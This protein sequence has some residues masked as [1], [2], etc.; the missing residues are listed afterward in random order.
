MSSPEAEV[1]DVVNGSPM[2]KEKSQD[3]RVRTSAYTLISLGAES[4]A[5][6]IKKIFGNL[7]IYFHPE[8]I[9][10]LI[11]EFSSTKVELDLPYMRQ[12]KLPSY[13]NYSLD[14][15]ICK[16]WFAEGKVLPKKLFS[17]KFIFHFLDCI[18]DENSV[19]IKIFRYFNLISLVRKDNSQFIY[20]LSF[21]VLR[22]LKKNKKTK[23][24][25]FNLIPVLKIRH[26]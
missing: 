13:S 6:F 9:A 5:H 11:N 7:N 4:F 8:T 16:Q 23:F 17:L 21:P 3:D 22:I 19:K 14:V 2:Y 18:K 12:I 10:L 24:Y 15:P 20:F 1:S 26:G 25:L